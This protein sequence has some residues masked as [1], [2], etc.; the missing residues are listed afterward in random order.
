MGGPITCA[1]CT[2]DTAMQGVG[3]PPPGA[4]LASLPSGPRW[5]WWELWS[6]IWARISRSRER[7]WVRIE[8]TV[9]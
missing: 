3:L 7:R 2:W 8:G 5:E 1:G 4:A 9:C 6:C